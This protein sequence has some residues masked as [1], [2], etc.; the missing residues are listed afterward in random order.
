MSASTQRAVSDHM[1]GPLE[2]AALDELV[3]TS[4]GQQPARFVCPECLLCFPSLT[5]LKGHW[6]SQHGDP[7]PVRTDFSRGA[8]GLNG[9]PTCKFCRQDF[10][11]WAYLE[12]HIT[13]QRCE[14][15]WLLDQAPAPDAL[16]PLEVPTSSA[17]LETG[18]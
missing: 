14:A 1:P 9:L 10:S 13:L 3:P 6:R 4:K 15:L 5:N 8:F 18:G 17:S 7:F 2:G 11:T 12:K 16:Q